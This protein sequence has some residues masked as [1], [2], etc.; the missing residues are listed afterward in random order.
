MSEEPT[1]PLC[2]GNSVSCASCN[3]IILYCP[4][5]KTLAHHPLTQMT[6][7]GTEFACFYSRIVS[8]E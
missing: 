1:R 4:I 5:F 6:P 3:S 8:E 2:I 7:N